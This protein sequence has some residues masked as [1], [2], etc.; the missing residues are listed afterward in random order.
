MKS[1]KDNKV[2]DS[3]ELPPGRKTVGSKWAYKRKTARLVAQGFTQKFGADCDETFCLV[4]HQE[5]LWVLLSLSVQYGLT[6]HQIDVATAFLNGNLEVE[7][8]TA[9]PEGFASKGSEH[10]VCRLK[11]SIYGLKQSPRCWNTTVDT[12]LRSIGFT[13]SNSNPCIYYRG[14]G[15]EIF[16]LGVYVDDIVLAAKTQAQF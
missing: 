14:T 8:Y 13:Q 3:V 9:Q 2:W 11:R 15:G 1:F 16:Y 6:L 12:Y 7:V 5:S 4:V 10:L